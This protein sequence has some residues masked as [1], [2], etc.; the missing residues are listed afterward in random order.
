MTA[1]DLHDHVWWY[2]RQDG[3]Y[4]I[5]GSQAAGFRLHIRDFRRIAKS[6]SGS[7]DAGEP[8]ITSA[9]WRMADDG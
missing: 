9:W 7:E 3:A 4:R 6:M 5:E 8:P 1:E 2:W